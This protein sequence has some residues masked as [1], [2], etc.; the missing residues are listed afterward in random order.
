MQQRNIS[1]ERERDNLDTSEGPKRRRSNIV[2]KTGLSQPDSADM[3]ERAFLGTTLINAINHDETGSKKASRVTAAAKS[4]T[5]ARKAN[6]RAALARDDLAPGQVALTYARP[7]TVA[8]IKEYPGAAVAPKRLD[9]AEAIGERHSRLQLFD[10]ELMSK[11]NR[12]EEM[13]SRP[14][15]QISNQGFK[16]SSKHMKA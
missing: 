11:G 3:E 14:M 2:M 10:S 9:S 15:S 7:S 4:D 12:I 13:V 6:A 8:K 1:N 5:K 16:A